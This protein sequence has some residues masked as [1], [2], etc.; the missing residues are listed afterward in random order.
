[1]LTHSFHGLGKRG[2]ELIVRQHNSE[3]M[4]IIKLKLSVYR[5]CQLSKD[6][7]F[8]LQVTVIIKELRLFYLG[9]EQ[10]LRSSDL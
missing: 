10:L 7:K 2:N 3:I 8:N 6:V 5:L 4:K 1:M 9:S